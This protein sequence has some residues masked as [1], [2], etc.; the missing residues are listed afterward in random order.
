M[1]QSKPNHI[2]KLEDS[3]ETNLVFI[4]KKDQTIVDYRFFTTKQEFLPDDE[5][6]SYFKKQ[7]Q[8]PTK[9]RSFDYSALT[10]L[11]EA[12]EKHPWNPKWEEDTDTYV[13]LKRGVT[14]GLFSEE[15]YETARRT[16][17]DTRSIGLLCEL[18]NRIRYAEHFNELSMPKGYL[19]TLTRGIKRGLYDREYVLELIKK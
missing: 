4:R 14:I 10:N 7:D 11:L 3:V 13:K 19:R 17:E 12:I 15:R 9:V 8:K 5:P 18:E 2:V 1:Q 16:Q 6:E